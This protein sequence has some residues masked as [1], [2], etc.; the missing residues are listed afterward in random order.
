M[1]Y[2]Y[3]Q[4]DMTKVTWTCLHVFFAGTARIHAVD[5]AELGIAETVFARLLLL[6]VEGLWIDDLADTHGL[7]FFGREQAELDFLDGAQGALGHNGGSWRRHGCGGVGV[8]AA[9]R[10]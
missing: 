2:G 8:T 4:L 6:V 3:G 1:E 10:E 9:M 5:A 7:Y